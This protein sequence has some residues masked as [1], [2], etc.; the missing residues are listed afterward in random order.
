MLTKIILNKTHR[1]THI[2]YCRFLILA[3]WY[4]Q[5]EQW[6]N[7]V[8]INRTK[9]MGQIQK[10]TNRNNSSRYSF[11]FA[12]WWNVCMNELHPTPKLSKIS[13]IIEKTILLLNILPMFFLVKVFWKCPTYKNK[14]F[15]CQCL[16]CSLGIR[17]EKLS[18]P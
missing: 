16:L 15:F 10:Q 1:I 8:W 6:I 13:I 5:L 9:Q 11:S 12:L 3:E 18:G 2:I 14:N 4:I 17:L 7:S